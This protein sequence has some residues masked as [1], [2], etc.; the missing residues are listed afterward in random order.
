MC[1][2]C[3]SLELIMVWNSC[4]LSSIFFHIADRKWVNSLFFQNFYQNNTYIYSLLIN[5]EIHRKTCTFWGE[6]GR[7]TTVFLNCQP[8]KKYVTSP[9]SKS[10]LCI[11]CDSKLTLSLFRSVLAF[12]YDRHNLFISLG[13]GPKP[14]QVH[15]LLTRLDF[16]ENSLKNS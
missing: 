3:Q 1:L 15:F 8:P 6:T 12:L 11:Y 9:M 5:E 2:G 14:S 4:L 16:G 7:D 10:T 13:H